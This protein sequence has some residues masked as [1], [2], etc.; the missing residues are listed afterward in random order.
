MLIYV[1]P[2]DREKRPVKAPAFELIPEGDTPSLREDVFSPDR[3]GYLPELELLNISD[4]KPRPPRRDFLPV[5]A[6]VLALI[7]IA[8]AV[9]VTIYYATRHSIVDS[10]PLK[11]VPATLPPAV[12][13]DPA[14]ADD[15]VYFPNPGVTLPVLKS[16]FEPTASTPGKVTLLVVID[17]AGIPQGARIWHGLDAATNVRAIQA[18]EKWRFRPGMKDGKPVPVIAQLE[19]NFRKE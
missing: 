3:G 4:P 10:T 17:P 19:I 16:K 5:V 15:T 1:E 18:S 2:S 9:R 6:T 8:I 12:Q 7:F 13:A 11:E 14:S